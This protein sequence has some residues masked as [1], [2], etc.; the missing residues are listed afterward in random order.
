MKRGDSVRLTNGKGK[1]IVLLSPSNVDGITMCMIGW[2]E[3]SGLISSSLP[4][5]TWERIEDLVL[6]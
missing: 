5:Y 2:G 1:G 6:C 4:R 3:W